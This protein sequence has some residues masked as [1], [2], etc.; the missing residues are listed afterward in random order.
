MIPPTGPALGFSSLGIPSASWGKAARMTTEAGLDFLEL[1][2]LGG[3]L[4]LP[5]LLADHTPRPGD[6][7]VRVMGTHVCLLGLDDKGVAEFLRFARLAGVLGTPWLRVFGTVGGAMAAEISPA[8][9][10]EAAASVKR[11]RDALALGNLACEPILETHDIFSSSERCLALN[12]RLAEPIRLLWDSHH[13]W[14][15]AEESPESTWSLLGPLVCHVHYKDSSGALGSADWH[16]VLPG[17]GEYPVARLRAVLAAA[18]YR[19]GVSLEWEKLWHP[20]L[21]P[22]EE[23]LPLFLRLFRP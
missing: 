11:L 5:T 3:T 19:G 17:R 1:R 13:T 23:A 2:S 20:E 6:P 4:D 22:L 9:L 18:G 7:P 15:L 21:P 12:K 10:D 8:Q 16:H 14:R